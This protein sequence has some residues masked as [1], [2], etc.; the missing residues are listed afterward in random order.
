Y[1]SFVYHTPNNNGGVSNGT[2]CPNGAAPATTYTVD[3]SGKQPPYAPLWTLS[4]GVQQSMPLPS[5]AMLIGS[6]RV[7]YQTRTL[8]ALEFLPVEEQPAYSMWDFDLTYHSPSDRYYFG[9]YVD[10]AFDKTAIGFSFLTPFSNMMTAT[11]QPPR[12]YGIRGGVH[13]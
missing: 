11:L 12:T 1:D 13:F 6:A 2:G 3:C 5:D 4:A 9:A 10:N 8:T 7:H